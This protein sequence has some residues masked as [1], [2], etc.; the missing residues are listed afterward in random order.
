MSKEKTLEEW[1]EFYNRK[2]PEPFERDEAGLLYY[3]SDKGFCEIDVTPEILTIFQ[4][5]GDIKFWRQAA[6][7]LCKS[8]KVKFIGVYI[9]RHVKPFI[10]VGGFRIYKTEEVPNGERYYFQDLKTGQKGQAQP[11]LIKDSG[12]IVY[13]ATVEVK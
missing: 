9:C 12:N 4:A 1:I 7:F 6:E 11:A 13:F 8:L 3:R 5:A 10:R 2:C